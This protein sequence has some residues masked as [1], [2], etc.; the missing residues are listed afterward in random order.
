MRTDAKLLTGPET[1]AAIRERT[2]DVLVSFSRGK[3]S[4]ATFLGIRDAFERVIPYTYEVVP[5]LEFVEDSLDYYERKIGQ[6]IWRYPAPGIFRMLNAM[7]YQPKE[8]LELIP[9]FDLPDITHDDIQKFACADAG[10]DYDTAYN[11]VGMRSKD[12]VQRAFSIQ[13]NG[14]I[15]HNRRIFYPIHE[16]DKDDVM[17]AVRDAGWLLPVDYRYFS[18]SFDGLYVKFLYPIKLYFPRDFQK[19][20][21]WFPFAELECLRYESAIR[22][23]EQPP[24]VHP[25]RAKLYEGIDVETGQIR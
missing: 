22:R 16:W 6:H 7:V 10:I 19:I 15:N 17:R 11:A 3:D 13:H 2:P 12:S 24:Y 4:L 8:R 25:P 18:A 9:R 20:C 23:G 5:G 14:S 1:I 21:D